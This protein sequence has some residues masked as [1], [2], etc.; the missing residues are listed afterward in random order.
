MDVPTERGTTT[1]GVGAVFPVE[2][3]LQHWS[4]GGVLVEGRINENAARRLADLLGVSAPTVGEPLRPMWHEVFLRERLHPVFAGHDGHPRRSALVPPVRRRQRL[5]G[6]GTL[7][8]LAPV[9]VGDTVARTVEIL[10]ANLVSGRSGEL[11]VVN[12]EHV[13][14]RDGEP[15]LREVR[16]IIYREIPTPT[17][18]RERAGTEAE[19]LPPATTHAAT[20]VI[21]LSAA[22]LVLYSELTGNGHRIH[23]DREYAQKV[24]G[25]DDLVVHGPLSALLA[26]EAFHRV[27]GKAATHLQYRLIAPAYVGRPLEVSTCTTADQASRTGTDSALEVE[28]RTSDL[29]ILRAGMS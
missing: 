21:T 11:L 4:P 7:T 1:G 15:C 22:D 10:S 19:L 29:R 27:T 3:V 23:I 26:A 12:E 18:R 6:G 28:V 17:P 24:E 9:R 16:D 13:W 2:Q 20:I 14:I 5:F 8:V 25:H